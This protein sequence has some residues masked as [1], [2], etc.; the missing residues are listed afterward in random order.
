MDLWQDRLRIRHSSISSFLFRYLPVSQRNAYTYVKTLFPLLSAD[1]LLLSLNV[2]YSLLT[3]D[4]SSPVLN[5]MLS[6]PSTLLLSP[7]P[8][9]IQYFAF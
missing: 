5:S 2:H 4:A 6:V 3:P 1:V 9:L 7:I 8:Q